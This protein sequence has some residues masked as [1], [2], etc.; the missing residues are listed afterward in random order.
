MLSI[1]GRLID[2][3]YTPEVLNNNMAILGIEP[4]CF[5]AIVLSHGHYDYFAGMVG[6]L[7]TLKYLGMSAFGYRA[8]FGAPDS[9]RSVMYKKG[10]VHLTTVSA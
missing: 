7:K 6:F 1:G 9:S 2:F 4:S 3:G 8:Y 5:D 10:F